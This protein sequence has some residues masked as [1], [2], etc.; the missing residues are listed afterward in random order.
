MGN[1]G[2]SRCGSGGSVAESDGMN[3][4]RRLKEE[5][6]ESHRDSLNSFSHS[7]GHE[8]VTL[9]FLSKSLPSALISSQ[10]AGSLCAETGAS[11]VLVRLGLHKGAAWGNGYRDSATVV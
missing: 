4:E 9:A 6:K 11:I 7:L 10:L 2:L 3:F 1:G 5:Q 8:V